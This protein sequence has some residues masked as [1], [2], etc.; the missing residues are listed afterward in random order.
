MATLIG[1]G[2]F[3]C[4][5][6]LGLLISGYMLRPRSKAELTENKSL[7]WTYGLG[8]WVLGGLGAWGAL[9]MYKTYFAP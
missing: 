1:I 8:V 4:G 7:R 9:E 5:F 3:I 2:G 6:A